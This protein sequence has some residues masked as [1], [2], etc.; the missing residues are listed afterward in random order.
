MIEFILNA[1]LC[2]TTLTALYN[3]YLWCFGLTIP[4]NLAVGFEARPYN[5]V[6]ALEDATWQVQKVLLYE[7]E[8]KDT[9][10]KH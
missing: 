10:R 9:K 7:E 3:T 2:C 1:Y 8:R 4:E 6:N 5:S